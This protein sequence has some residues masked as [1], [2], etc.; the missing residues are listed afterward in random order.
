MIQGRI[1]VA[2]DETL[3]FSRKKRKYPLYLVEIM[4]Y[5]SQKTVYV[6]L[7]EITGIRSIPY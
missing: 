3:K 5:Y 2:A 4:L 7:P 1:C 6:K